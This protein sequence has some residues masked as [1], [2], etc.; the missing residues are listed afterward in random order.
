MNIGDKVRLLH[1]KE[2]GVIYAFLPGNVVE[3]E[4]E[5]G[6]RIPVMRSEVVAVS[7]MEAQRMAPK[8]VPTKKEN[9]FLPAFSRSK[10]PFAEKGIYLAFVAS[11]DRELVLHLI[12][13]SDWTL[14]FVAYRDTEGKQ[15]GMG[16]GT[17][18]PRTS[19]RLT[20]LLTKDFEQWPSFDITAL[21]YREGSGEM[22]QPFQKRIR[23]RAQSF[24]KRKQSA[25]VLNKEAYVYQLDEDVP[26][27]PPVAIKIPLATE[28]LPKATKPMV[29]G[30]SAAELGESLMSGGKNAGK[31]SEP[32]SRDQA[33]VSAGSPSIVDLHLEKL[34]D[35]PETLTN[36]EKLTLQLDTFERQF[37]RAIAAG[38][39]EITFIHG[40]GNGVLRAELH[41]RLSKH[42]NVQY[43]ED[44]QKEQFGFGATFVKIK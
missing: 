11:N 30:P 5:E 6:F 33:N 1:G 26:A 35:A 21:Y 4:I 9:D 27:T 23:C 24:Y 37:E 28:D 18:L 17:L 31:A 7:P 14:P 15:A 39:D 42:Q 44:A 25:P 12:N 22:K 41:R 32:S 29:D 20:D 36:A 3:I 40:A 8:P 2:E 10:A 34:S 16:A 38:R 13:N 43:Y 19:Q